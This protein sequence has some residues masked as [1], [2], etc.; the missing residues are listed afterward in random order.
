[1][2]QHRRHTLLFTLLS[3]GMA[4]FFLWDL[5]YGSVRIPLPDVVRTLFGGEATKAS[6]TY[7]VWDFRLPKALT[8][9]MAGMALSVSGLMM[10]TF[11]R[12]PLAGPYVL[13]L[14]SGSSLAVAFVVMGSA[15]LPGSIAMALASP[16]GVA[17]ASCIGSLV[18]LF[19]VLTVAR[20]LRDTM[21]ILIVGLMFGSFTSAITGILSYLS[22]A[23]QLQRFTFWSLGSLG[24]LSW[25]AVAIVAIGTGIGLALAAFCIKA[26][27]ALLLGE[28]Y[29]QTLG[30]PM[31]RTRIWVLLSVGILAGVITAFA[32]PIA[33][34]G[35]AVPHIARL[36][37]RTSR[38]S[39]LFFA[40]LLLGGAIM[41]VCDSLC[42]FPGLEIQLP[43]NAVTSLLGAPM[44]IWL[45]LNK[46]KW[47]S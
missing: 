22:T 24:N 30:I 47:A 1:M 32:G 26:L 34:V 11:F 15:F 17:A 9:V 8:A 38:H 41:L 39:V 12:N 29:A 13:G 21:S 27:D 20:R 43:I 45:L 44:V 42:Q 4:V 14:S 28:H 36:L 7:I 2:T 3:I 5:C 46:R 35:L 18:V 31:A 37:F 16:Y 25:E 6:W 19:A 33:F 10:Q 40:T 23:E